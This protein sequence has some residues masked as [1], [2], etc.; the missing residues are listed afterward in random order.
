M[1]EWL[2]ALAERHSLLAFEGMEW[3]DFREYADVVHRD[4]HVSSSQCQAR[5][6]SCMSNLIER[7]PHS[8][9]VYIIT[10]IPEQYQN[11][12]TPA[13]KFRF[14]PVYHIGTRTILRFG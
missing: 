11:R 14:Q 8:K 4:K 3:G 1:N 2:P 5:L 7:I 12:N 13:L 10:S 9:H 6:S